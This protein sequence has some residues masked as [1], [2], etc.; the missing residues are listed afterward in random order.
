MIN[1]SYYAL[2]LSWNGTGIDFLKIRNL[3]SHKID[4]GF[5]RAVSLLYVLLVDH[6]LLRL[7]WRNFAIV[8]DKVIRSNHLGNFHLTK[9]KKNGLRSIVN[10]RGGQQ[11]AQNAFEKEF[12]QNNKVKYY[13]IPLASTQWPSK[14]ALLKLI[15]IF[16]NA[17]SKMLIHCKSGADRTGLVVGIYLIWKLKV[18][19]QEAKKN[20]SIRFLHWKHGK[21]GILGE[22]FDYYDET[23]DGTVDFSEW[24]KVCYLKDIENKKAA[25]EK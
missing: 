8:D 22:F 16:E 11:F 15:D 3:I 7:V 2:S 1:L 19:G 9:L 24:V 14:H 13:N 20:L 21:K 4:S 10:L 23:S 5:P 12:C 18:S 6:G 25:S 17:D